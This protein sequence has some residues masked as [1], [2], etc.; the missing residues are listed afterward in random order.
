M[1]SLTLD[2]LLKLS[3]TTSTQILFPPDCITLY[4]TL[5]NVKTWKNHPSPI[6]GSYQGGQ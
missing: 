4:N 1:L 5:I 2:V 3:K 6:N